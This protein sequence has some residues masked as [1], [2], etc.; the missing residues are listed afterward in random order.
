MDMLQQYNSTSDDDDDTKEAA[1][2]AAAAEGSGSHAAAEEPGSPAPAVNTAGGGSMDG[3]ACVTPNQ[4]KVANLC[5]SE[6]RVMWTMS[7]TASFGM[8]PGGT[9]YAEED[10]EPLQK[11]K[12]LFLNEHGN[13]D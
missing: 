3:A 11:G 4:R 9:V 12:A 13:N 8:S 6:E 7:P 1:N 10:L 5:K 2:E